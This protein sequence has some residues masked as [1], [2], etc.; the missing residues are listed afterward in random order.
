VGGPIDLDGPGT[1]EDL[2]AVLVGVLMAWCMTSR[3][4]F[5]VPHGEGWCSVG[6]S[7]EQPHFDILDPL[8][9]DGL[10]FHLIGAAY[11]HERGPPLFF[12]GG[13][14]RNRG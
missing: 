13:I 11:M 14:E 5:E 12:Y 3:R 10:A 8:H 4:D 7:E 6:S 1:L 2:D 9:F